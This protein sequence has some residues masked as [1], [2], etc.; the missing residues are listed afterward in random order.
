[1][2][3]EYEHSFGFDEQTGNR[4][5]RPK[6]GESKASDISGKRSD[7]LSRARNDFRRLVNTNF[8]TGN[9]F[10]T[11]TFRDNVTDIDEAM[12]AWRIY[13]KALKKRYGDFKYIGVREFQKRGAI[14]FHVIADIDL[15]TGNELGIIWGHGYVT[16]ERITDR[17]GHG[18]DNVGAYLI[19]YLSKDAADPRLKG[20]K[21]YFASRGLDRPHTFRGS[22]AL[23]LLERL[24]LE[25]KQPVWA[26]EY[27]G[28]YT[29]IVK[30]R[31]YNLDRLDKNLF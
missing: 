30:Y 29:G 12:E 26:N 24:Q 21:A 5:V 20:K 15:S 1:M 8:Y 2:V 13:V 23:D 17:K 18:V 7:N 9:W 16:C 22:E 11:V 14:H 19:K 31:E 10:I 6:R 4:R 3:Y 25:R 28:K 27:E